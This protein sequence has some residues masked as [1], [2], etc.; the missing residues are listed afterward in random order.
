[1]TTFVYCRGCGH[2]IHETAPKCPKCGA[3]Q[4][5]AGPPAK[6]S[7][8]EPGEQA[9]VP[10]ER[11]IEPPAAPRPKAVRTA[12]IMLMAVIAL[13][14]LQVGPRANEL[15]QRGE[16][17]EVIAESVATCLILGF[18]IAKISAGKN[19]ARY[20]LLVLFITGAMPSLGLHGG[21]KSPAIASFAFVA[22]IL[23]QLWAMTLLFLK[24][25]RTWFKA[26]K[27]RERHS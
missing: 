14:V 16:L 12:S 15:I 20:A 2:Q 11:P 10:S 5:L 19:W 27:A 21:G 24:P 23:L 4:S 7:F 18:V 25:A 13:G 9:L 8:S 26:Q 22:A 17:L 6:A 3:P 1:M